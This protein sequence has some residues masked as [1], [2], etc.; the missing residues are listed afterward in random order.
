MSV[1]PGRAQRAECDSYAAFR[2]A[3]G[4]TTPNNLHWPGAAL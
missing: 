4:D 1:P 3:N 2:G